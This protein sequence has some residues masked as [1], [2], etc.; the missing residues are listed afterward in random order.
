MI[1]RPPRS[2]LFPYTTLFRS[3][4]EVLSEF[5]T[6]NV[7]HQLLF[8]VDGNWYNDTFEFSTGNVPA[9]DI[10][11]PNYDVTTPVYT[12]AFRDA[13]YI[14]RYGLYLQDQI[15]FSD[16]IQM[17]IGGRF[18]LISQRTEV[19]GEATQE[20]DDKIGRAHV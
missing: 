10:Q 3:N 5:E 8:G 7:S 19:E 2:T 9:L 13:N 17:L 14:D 12:P 4:V 15:R 1:R 16:S 20:Q 6:G 11:N 18:D